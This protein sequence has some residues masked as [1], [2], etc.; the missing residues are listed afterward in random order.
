M[1]I[2]QSQQMTFLCATNVVVILF[3]FNRLCLNSKMF[4][5][6]TSSVVVHLSKC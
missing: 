5:C 2:K 6:T 3:T 4:D 1:F